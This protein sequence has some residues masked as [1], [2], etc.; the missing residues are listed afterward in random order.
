MEFGGPD[1]DDLS[2]GDFA[3]STSNRRPPRRGSPGPLALVFLVQSTLVAVAWLLGL[4]LKDSPRPGLALNAGVMRDGMIATVPLLM[5][6][7][8]LMV[9]SWQPIRRLRSQ[10]IAF[11]GPLF[12]TQHWGALILVAALA[13]FG[14]ELLFRGTIQPLSTRWLSQSFASQ[15]GGWGSALLGNVVTSLI[16]AALHGVSR[17]Y[18]A[19]AFMISLYFG[20]IS[21]RTNQLV[22]VMLAHGIY[23]LV[24]LWALVRAYRGSPRHSLND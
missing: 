16:F 15:L 14:E 1:I 10:S 17:A 24:A 8:V 18:F 11:L 3:R 4:L 12:Q 6:L 19:L 21:Q 2:P 9:V 5:G 13:G 23:D 20:W 7:W 22:P